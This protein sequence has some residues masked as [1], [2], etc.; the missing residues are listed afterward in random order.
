MRSKYETEYCSFITR[1]C[2]KYISHHFQFLGLALVLLLMCILLKVYSPDLTEFSGIGFEQPVYIFS[3]RTTDNVVCI[4]TNSTP[5]TG[6]V[7]IT[8]QSEDISATGNFRFASY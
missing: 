5:L 3:E 7:E 8:V 2:H 6:S 1:D 4:A